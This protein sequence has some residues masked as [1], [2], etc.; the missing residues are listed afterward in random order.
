ME[1]LDAMRARLRVMFGDDHLRDLVAAGVRD[2]FRAQFETAGAAGHEPWAPLDPATVGRRGDTPWP[3]LDS[4]LPGV[5]SGTL[6]RSLTESDNEYGY[7]ELRD[8]G[9]TLAVGTR[10]EYAPYFS[11]GT[12][13]Q[14]PRPLP[15]DY[16]PPLAAENLA[17]TIG[18]WIV[19]GEQGAESL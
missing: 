5:R 13:R 8:G 6:E 2:I 11:D 19:E 17:Q 10:L 4:T 3:V 12:G 18:S 16:W 9:D 14:P 1:T 15:P 7:A